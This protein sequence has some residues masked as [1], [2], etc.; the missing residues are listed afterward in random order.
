MLEKRANRSYENNLPDDSCGLCAL[1]EEWKILV[2]ITAVKMF[3]TYKV[4]F[5]K[6]ENCEAISNV[7]ISYQKKK[8]ILGKWHIAQAENVKK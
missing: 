6:C 8:F 3:Q 2:D 1:L 5:Y 4:S 7:K